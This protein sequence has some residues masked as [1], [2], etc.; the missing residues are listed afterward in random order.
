[1]DLNKNGLL[2]LGEIHMG[3]E[4]YYPQFYHK[5]A[6]LRA[7][8]AAD[9][10]GDGFIARREFRLLL[11]YLVFFSNAWTTF[12]AFDVDGDHRLAPDEFFAGC[13]RLGLEI[14]AE[15]A[16]DDF[17]KIETNGGGYV[18]FEKFYCWAGQR[19]IDE[20]KQL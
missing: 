19:K 4:K 16:S 13:Q 20:T 14:T 3:V 15:E 6:T 10:N 18:L 7:C 8:K 12:D 2:S 11:E 1:M 9:V 5:Q 17:R